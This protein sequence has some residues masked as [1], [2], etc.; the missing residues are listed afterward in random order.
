MIK[1]Q[2]PVLTLTRA[3]VKIIYWSILC[4]SK[5]V[6][7]NV[8]LKNL[9]PVTVSNVDKCEK[10]HVAIPEE[11]PKHLCRTTQY[12]YTTTHTS[13][14]SAFLTMKKSTSLYWWFE[15]GPD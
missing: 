12:R 7:S 3:V 5:L 8:N 6:K 10:S 13:V 9:A 2:L 15:F 14:Y 1:G 11:R 4:V